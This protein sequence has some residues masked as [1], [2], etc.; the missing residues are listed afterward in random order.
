MKNSI[1]IKY[2]KKKITLLFFIV[3]SPAIIYGQTTT[4]SACNR[5]MT[6]E[7][8]FKLAKTL[9]KQDVIN[10]IVQNCFSLYDQDNGNGLWDKKRFLKKYDVEDNYQNITYSH[11]EIITIFLDKFS[12]YHC[13]D[14]KQCQRLIQEIKRKT[15]YYT[16][17]LDNAESYIFLL[18]DGR[19][20]VELINIKADNG[21]YSYAFEIKYSFPSDWERMKKEKLSDSFLQNKNDIS[22]FQYR[23]ANVFD[24][25][26]NTGIMIQSGDNVKFESWGEINL[27]TFAGSTGPNG[28]NG[29][30]SYNVIDNYKHGCLLYKIGTGNWAPVGEELIVKASNS[31]QLY[32]MVNDRET[33]NNR[34]DFSI[35]IKILPTNN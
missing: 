30:T 18:N 9:N 26:N 24:K 1:S 20:K 31:G 17:S 3:I 35:N 21:N 32:F 25:I 28:I 16:E 8:I 5:T 14:T 27:G 23:Y 11:G 7:E 12:R 33:A 34:G 22:K 29:Y 4:N 6:F 2:L 10:L 15:I 19:Y 13:T